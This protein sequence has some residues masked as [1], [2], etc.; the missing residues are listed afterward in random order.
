[1]VEI[2]VLCLSKTLTVPIA[3]SCIRKNWYSWLAVAISMRTPSLR[4]ESHDRE[5]D[6]RPIDGLGIR[7]GRREE[8]AISRRRLCQSWL[9]NPQQSSA[10]STRQSLTAPCQSLQ[11]DGCCDVRVKI[12]LGRKLT[13]SV[14]LRL[15][16]IV[17]RGTVGIS[18]SRYGAAIDAA[19][20]R[21][22][23]ELTLAQRC[24]L[25]G[26]PGRPRSPSDDESPIGN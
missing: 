21:S 17:G 25:A 23:G 6:A 3:T 4:N 2:K 14:F 1:M 13:A 5:D 9:H 8:A 20:E 7:V 18:R 19:D 11:L 24:Q 22:S 10:Q 12:K 16:D 26:L 15:R